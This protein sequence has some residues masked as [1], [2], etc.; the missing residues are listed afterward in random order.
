MKYDTI[1]YIISFH[2]LLF[3]TTYLCDLFYYKYC[4]YSMTSC[5]FN[6]VNLACFHVKSLSYAV[7][8]KNYSE[9]FQMIF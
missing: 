9:I 8:K 5:Y 7:N 2:I 1:F 4:C 6:Q 3:M